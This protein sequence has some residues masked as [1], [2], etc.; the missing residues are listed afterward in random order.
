MNGPTAH[1]PQ[2]VRVAG[3]PAEVIDSFSHAGLLVALE[4]RERLQ[5]QLATQRAALVDCLHAAIKRDSRDERRFLLSVK[6]H[7][8]NTRDLKEFRQDQ[9]W[10][11][12]AEVAGTLAE[13]VVAL[14]SAIESAASN[15]GE[16]YRRELQQERRSLIQLL[17]HRAFVRGLTLASPIVVQNLGSL[18][19]GRPD[20]FGRREKRLCLTLLRYASRSPQAFPFSTFT[21]TA[22]ASVTGASPGDFA[23]APGGPWQERSTTC[24]HRELLA[25]CA[26]LLLR[27]RTLAEGLPVMLNETLM[28]GSDGRYSFFRPGRWEFDD[29][30]KAFR[31]IEASAVR[32]KLEGALVSWV[33]DE[34]RDGPRI[35]RELLS[36]WQSQ[37]GEESSEL[38]E[39][40]ATALLGLGFLNLM[41]CWDF[42]DPDLKQQI[43]DC[44]DILPDSVD[45]AP[46]R[47]T[48]RELIRSLGNYSSTDSPAAFL[49]EIRER[50]EE[51]FQALAS[52]AGLPG[53]EF[54]A[55][56]FN[57]EEIVFLQREAP[58]TG[59]REIGLL[60]QDRM[61]RLLKDLDPLVRLSNLYSSVHDLLHTLA[62]F[63]ERRWPGE[64]EVGLLEFFNG[65]QP[66]FDQY[67][68]YRS[69][70]L[71]NPASQPP[72]FNP[73]ELGSVASLTEWRRR[74]E[75]ELG[76]C[77][78]EEDQ[79][80]RLGPNTLRDLL[81]QVPSGYARSR[82]FCAFLQP[83]DP[84]GHLWVL[85]SMAEGYGRYGS[86]FNTGMDEET[87]EHWT[88]C[89]TPLS[90]FDLDGERVELV[91]MPFPGVRTINVHAVQTYR[92]LKMPGE[93][94]PLPA[95]RILRLS[96]LR[97]RLRGGNQPPVLTDAAGQRLL[98]IQLGSL[99]PQRRP[100]LLKFLAAF[101][102]GDYDPRNPIRSPRT[103]DGVEVLDRH[104]LGQIVYARK[105]WRLESQPLLSMIEGMDEVRTFR[106]IHRWRISRDIPSR[107]F[108]REPTTG[109]N[110]RPRP[111]YIDFSSPS[112]VQIFKS[113]LGNTKTLVMEEALPAPERFPMRDGR[114]GVEVQLES[115]GFG[116]PGLFSPR[117]VRGATE[118]VRSAG[119]T[120]K[121][122]VP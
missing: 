121:E 16:S 28:T 20:D 18:L 53:I 40:G 9:R 38:I 41:P 104:I 62:A 3:L 119:A 118:T 85:N 122:Q 76:A 43:L 99:A 66:L 94:S 72:G 22:L 92:I 68:R 113:V 15:L 82:E 102:P 112:F 59:T 110:S 84:D 120:R 37:F 74:I 87:R 5:S 19:Q 55:S 8:F 10:S 115:L 103:N 75:S 11:L 21:R 26:S 67:L 14:E 29:E 64:Q 106:E 50:V 105:K 107:V 111:Q 4:E 6:R 81:D 36:Q 83:L 60:S 101:G 65:A 89:F 70:F 96:D 100:T 47:N 23:L 48:F 35:Y 12:L 30:T 46:F 25:Q 42:N 95:E 69:T 54:T 7:C 17:E 90:V 97:I 80:Q 79:V 49:E 88:S 33:L 13:V 71:R 61:C 116:A 91:D 73:L 32:V 45:L 2:I 86:R 109:T 31:Y 27:H 1:P 93:Q 39:S 114:W 34:L 117:D 56:C 24:L 51:L 58:V 77:L 63:G 44:L 108:A 57:F 98:P 52:P 78:H